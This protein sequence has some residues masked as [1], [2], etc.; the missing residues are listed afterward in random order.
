MDNNL[1]KPDSGGFT[2][3]PSVP[4]EAPSTTTPPPPGRVKAGQ[5]VVYVSDDNKPHFPYMDSKTFLSLV[6]G[7]LTSLFVTAGITW[8]L[9]SIRPKEEKPAKN[10]NDQ[11][12]IAPTPTS[13]IIPTDTPEPL[14]EA[15][16]SAEPSP[17]AG[18]TTAPVAQ[19]TSKTYT[20]SAGGFSFSYPISLSV[21]ENPASAEKGGQ[22]PA[23]TVQIASQTPYFL[24]NITYKNVG[25]ISSLTDY[26][27]EQDYCASHYPEKSVAYSV[28]G[29]QGLQYADI[30]CGQYGSTAIVVYKNPFIYDIIVTNQVQYSAV[31]SDI[32]SILSTMK[33]N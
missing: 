14:V 20:S 24:L 7:I 18:I 13:E 28:S 19:P 9:I 3:P 5:Q 32:E 11:I 21:N 4:T 22:N 6:I 1:P 15:S 8:Y 2:P 16:P 25:A 30:P 26:M 23:N 12:A 17:A 27:K 31:K 29:S 33:F 10:T